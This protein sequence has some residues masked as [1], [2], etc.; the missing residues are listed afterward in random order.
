MTIFLHSSHSLTTSSGT[1]L[2]HGSFPVASSPPPIIPS[3][4]LVSDLIVDM[5]D[6]SSSS[7]K[8]TRTSVY[9]KKRPSPH[10]V[11]K[12]RKQSSPALPSAGKSS[13]CRST[14]AVKA[15]LQQRRQREA[16][17]LALHREGVLLEEEYR[18]EIQ[19]YMHQMEVSFNSFIS[20]THR[21]VA[22]P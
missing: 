22:E 5:K 14:P 20:F 17:V 7:S 6:V 9:P 21:N 12:S 1:A 18:E 2:T 13:A 11:S 19:F 15:A 3:S 10:G 8:H 16:Q 4:D